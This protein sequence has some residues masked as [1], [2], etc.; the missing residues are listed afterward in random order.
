MTSKSSV[1]KR[2]ITT[3]KIIVSHAAERHGC[4]EKR[5]VI[6]KENRR[7]IRIKELR[8]Y[9]KSHTKQYKRAKPIEKEPLQK[10]YNIIWSK[11]RSLQRAEWQ[12][13]WRKRRV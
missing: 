8:K 2:L 6:G 3:A 12:R 7:E 5:N 9:L 11:L 1:D 13:W 10:L 4:E